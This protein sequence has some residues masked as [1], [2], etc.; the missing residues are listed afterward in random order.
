MN[1]PLVVVTELNHVSY[2]LSVERSHTWPHYG[3]LCPITALAVCPR[4][5]AAQDTG[6]AGH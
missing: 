1:D 3:T 2:V 6:I 5:L 4:T